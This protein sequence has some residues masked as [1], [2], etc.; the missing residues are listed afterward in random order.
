VNEG[1]TIE[2]LVH[3]LLSWWVNSLRE[4]RERVGVVAIARVLPSPPAR[5][6]VL[7]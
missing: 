5:P 7:A 1:E 4:V 3:G 6:L 2:I